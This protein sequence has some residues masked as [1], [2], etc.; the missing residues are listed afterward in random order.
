M[1]NGLRLN[2]RRLFFLCR[3]FIHRSGL[4]MKRGWYRHYFGSRKEGASR[5]SAFRP[6]LQEGRRC[7]AGSRFKASL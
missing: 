4:E 6:R 5:P 2:G 7:T 3:I 1:A